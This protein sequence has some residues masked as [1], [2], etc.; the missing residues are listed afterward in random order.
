MGG[1]SLLF[2]LKL[3]EFHFCKQHCQVFI[4]DKHVQE[5]YNIRSHIPSGSRIV[6]E[7]FLKSLSIVHASLQ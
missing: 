2:K 7:A 4:M 3:K 5:T 1:G 6:G